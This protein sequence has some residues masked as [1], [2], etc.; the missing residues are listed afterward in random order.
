ML[1]LRQVAL[2]AAD[3]EPAVEDLNA[4]LGLEVGFRDPGVGKYGLENVVMPVGDTFL[5]IVSPVEEGTTAGRFLARRGG[6]GGYM[7]IL[8]TD[9]IEDERRR[10]E[11]MGIRI[12]ERIDR[13]NAWGTHLH[14]KDVGGA[15]LSIDAMSPPEEWQWAGPEWREHVNTET[16]AG[17]VGV[18]IQAE[19]PEEMAARWGEVLQREVK[20]TPQG[21]GIG[22]DDD[23]LI[24]FVEVDDERGEGVSGVLVEV[25]DLKHVQFAAGQ[26]GINTSRFSFVTCGTRFY[27]SEKHK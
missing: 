7:V 2:V 13:E 12:V 10:I 16:A 5:E 25:N 9:R 14:P 15:I 6:D 26:R 3:L 18:E 4:V 27:V 22:L 19:Q 1:R 20:K 23:G 11:D 21:I 24:R 8:Q 17:I